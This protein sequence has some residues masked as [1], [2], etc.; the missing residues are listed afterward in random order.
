MVIAM[1]HIKWCITVVCA[2]ILCSKELPVCMLQVSKDTFVAALL[3]FQDASRAIEQRCL[4][5]ETVLQRK[6]FVLLGDHAQLPPVCRCNRTGESSANLLCF[7][8]KIVGH[9]DVQAVH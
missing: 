9:V 3:R 1:S 5:A 8:L 7:L 6:L 2:V 4:D